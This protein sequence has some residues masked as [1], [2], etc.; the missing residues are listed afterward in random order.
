MTARAMELAIANLGKMREKGHD[1]E[2]ILNRSTELSY[3]GLFEPPVN[4]RRGVEA[5]NRQA[6]EE[7]LRGAPAEVIDGNA[8]R[9]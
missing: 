5:G 4:G 7:W 1:P 3:R 2:A 6:V 9:E 8:T